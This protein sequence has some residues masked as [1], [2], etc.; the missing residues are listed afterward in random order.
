MYALKRHPQMPKSTKSSFV[1][2]KPPA[3]RKRPA[4]T[5]TH[6]SPGTPVPGWRHPRRSS[7]PAARAYQSDTGAVTYQSDKASDP[8]A[9]AEMLEALEFLARVVSHIPN[10]GQVLQ[11]Y[12]GWYANRPRGIPRRAGAHEQPPTR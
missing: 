2:K 6:S 11:R 9:G 3:P 5:P 7:P 8:T 4:A 1:P 12:Y 10:K